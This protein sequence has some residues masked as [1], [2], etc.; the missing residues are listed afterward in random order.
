M[1]PNRMEQLDRLAEASPLDITRKLE[2][3]ELYDK[4][5]SQA[6]IDE[7]YAEF[8]SGG[9]LVKQV[10][11]PVILSV[12]DGLLEATAGGRAARKKGLTASRVLQECEQFSYEGPLHDTG[13]VDG[14]TEFKN[15]REQ[16]SVNNN[17]TQHYERDN[18]EDKRAMR[19]YKEGKL[20]GEKTLKDEYT[21]KQNLYLLRKD[22]NLRHPDQGHSRQAQPDHIVPLKQIHDQFKGNYA[23][24]DDDIRRIANMDS[25]L[26][27]T[28]AA[29]NQTKKER[30]NAEYIQYM[31]KDGRPV[32]E[33][34]RARM[35]AMQASAEKAVNREANKTVLRN[36]TGGGEGHTGKTKEI[37]GIA[38]GNA[39]K[40]A[41]DYAVGNLILFI[42]KPLYY[43]IKDMFKNGMKGGVGASSTMDALKTRFGRVKDYTVANAGAFLGDSMTDFVKG[44]VSSLIEGIISLFVGVFKQ[45]LKLLKE[46]IKI[47]VSSA[48]LLFGEEGKALSPSERGDAIIKLLGGSVIAIAGIGIE[49]LLNKIGIGE[50]LSVILSTMLAGIASALFMFLLDKADLFSVKAE[51]RRDRIEDIFAERIQDIRQVSGS[52]DSAAA[53]ALRRQYHSFEATRTRVQQGFASS[54][55]DEVNAGLYKLAELFKVELPYR[56]TEE[57]VNYVQSKPR[58]EL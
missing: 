36:L 50:P 10:V 21:G 6:I 25:N 5:S 41:S 43:E 7:V 55:M 12:V 20:I 28:S 14:Y 34:T 31:D 3:F 56:N 58:L 57:F 11:N 48:K 32:D 44:F 19:E 1:D 18:Y 37:Y 17:F 45:V 33:A 29:I 49:A 16:D 4:K 8:Q 51:K 54:N 47:F 40:Q 30:S 26:A 13:A 52:F 2:S 38:A 15:A 23:L 35:L 22:P 42:L 9:N 46:G 27:V 53:E 24:D 39:A